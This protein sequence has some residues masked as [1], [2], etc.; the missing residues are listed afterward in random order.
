M[1]HRNKT[2]KAAV[3]SLID[4][5][6][7]FA[8]KF[9]FAIWI[10]RLLNPHDY[11]LIAYTGLFLG[12]ATWLSEGGFGTALIQKK[13]ATRI[14]YSTGFIFN[15]VISVLFFTV[16][17]FISPTVADFFH[18]PELKNILRITSMNLIINSLC[19][20]HLIK[21]TKSLQF[22]Q[23]AIINFLASILSGSIG[24]GLALSGYGYWA[25]VYQTL[26]GSFLRMIGFWIAIKW[27]PS[28]V[29]KWR[30]FIEQFQFGSKVFVQGLFES[31][32][33]EIHSIVIGRTYNTNLLGNYSR[34]QKFYDLIIV[35][36]GIAINKVMYPTLARESE[37]YLVHKSL[38]VRTYGILFFI[39]APISLFM[40]LFSKPFVRILLTDKWM[41]AAPFLQLYFLAGFI[42]LLVY[43]NSTTVLS[44]NR[45]RLYLGLDVLQKSLF[46]IALIITYQI[47]IKAIIIGWIVAY[48]IYYFT[49][50]VVMHTLH[51]SYKNKYVKMMQVIICLIPMGLMYLFTDQVLSKNW[52]LQVN[53]VLQPLVYFGTMKLLKFD[54]FNEFTKIAVAFLPKFLRTRKY[55]N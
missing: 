19:Y 46:A 5:Y 8:L 33:R 3:W 10:T 13:E 54:V 24:L 48:Y 16:Y 27:L 49:Y 17:Y 9:I 32:F 35:Q 25:L 21:L 53:I 31:I 52:L 26:I 50:E 36:T 30:S 45:P 20:A 51:Y 29:F 38:Y 55:E 39:I 6:A 42:Y 43:F 1:S 12:I 18:E 22:K 11:G 7:G 44:S 41:A 23:Q 37:N 4:T 14:D 47:S 15:V 34:G 28:P 2:A 40:I